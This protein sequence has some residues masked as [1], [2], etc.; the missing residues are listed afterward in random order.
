VCR[1]EAYLEPT[2]K[3][4]FFL[5]LKNNLPTFDLKL[6]KEGEFL[7][8]TGREFRAQ[9]AEGRPRSRS[10]VTDRENSTV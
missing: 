5:P 1:I 7:I 10:P 2:S 8:S 6:P 9:I 4:V 3:S